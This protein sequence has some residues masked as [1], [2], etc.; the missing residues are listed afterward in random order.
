M[1]ITSYFFHSKE[2][3]SQKTTLNRIEFVFNYMQ[4][5][6]IQVALDV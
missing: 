5:F 2:T 6:F 4:L 3:A 1:F